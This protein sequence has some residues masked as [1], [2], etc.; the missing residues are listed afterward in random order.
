MNIEEMEQLLNES[1]KKVAGIKFKPSIKPLD[2]FYNLIED[3]FDGTF[4]KS[5][6][7]NLEAISSSYEYPDMYYSL[8]KTEDNYLLLEHAYRKYEM[9]FATF[10]EFE[11]LENV[12]EYIINELRE[13]ANTEDL[14]K[15]LDYENIKDHS[16]TLSQEDFAGLDDYEISR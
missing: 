6:W 2:E 12:N 1:P 7:L 14:D 5:V 4:P 3:E 16:E 8:T 11:S 13:R 9:D 10:Q 15:F